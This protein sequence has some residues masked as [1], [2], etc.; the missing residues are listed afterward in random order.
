[1]MTE[2]NRVSF[3]VWANTSDPQNLEWIYPNDVQW[4]HLFENDKGDQVFLARVSASY[5]SS[6]E[7]HLNSDSGVVLYE[8]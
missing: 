5:A 3:L 7:T 2:E 6:F 4:Q 1:M 8:C